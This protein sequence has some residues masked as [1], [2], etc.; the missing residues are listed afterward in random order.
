MADAFI[1]VLSDTKGQVG[2]AD[3][4]RLRSQVMIGKNKRLD[5]RRSKRAARR[6][7]EV[8]DVHDAKSITYPEV[9]RSP[10]L[11]VKLIRFADEVNETSRE[12]LQRC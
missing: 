7:A 5:S 9:P 11:D 6:A 8:Q 10:P 3:R 4:S 2:S 1:F 12:Y